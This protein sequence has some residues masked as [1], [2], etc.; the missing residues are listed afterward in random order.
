MR[1]SDPLAAGGG[2]DAGLLRPRS[3]GELLDASFGLYRRHF[4]V[5]VGTALLLAI[6][7]IAASA[8]QPLVGT[9]LNLLTLPL[10]AAAS[11]GVVGQA[12]AGKK[13]RL[14]AALRT[15]FVRGPV[16]MLLSI[17]VYLAVSAAMMPVAL[18][19]LLFGFLFGGLTGATLGSAAGGVVVIAGILAGGALIAFA[20]L[21]AYTFLC[22]YAPVW[23]FEGRFWGL[24]RSIS[25]V[26]GA[27]A[28]SFFANLISWLLRMLPGLAVMGSAA[29]LGG[30]VEGFIESEGQDPL[31]NALSVAVNAIVEPFA[32]VVI[33]L[34]YV[35]RRAMREGLDLAPA[36]AGEP[37]AL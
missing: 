7:A 15:A 18:I 13:P 37:A 19:V 31:I 28:K 6:P 32:A 21:A 29:I 27:F 9:F 30:G 2:L 25:L 10:I 20:A 23:I 26:R 24:G 14:A 12:L 34:L 33:A 3:L 16:L 22:L 36:E 35:D 1:A 4:P 8:V 11:F 17:L 5:L